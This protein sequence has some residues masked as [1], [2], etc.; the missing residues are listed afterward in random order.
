MRWAFNIH[1]DFVSLIDHPTALPMLEEWVDRKLRLDHACGR[2][3]PGAAH[4]LG[5]RALDRT[6]PLHFEV[7]DVLRDLSGKHN[8]VSSLAPHT[9][10]EVAWACRLMRCDLLHKLTKSVGTTCG[11][12]STGAS[13]SRRSRT[14]SR[15]T[16]VSCSHE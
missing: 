7:H 10:Y 9:R 12:R 5:Q 1:R 3:P 2:G 15:P 6:P 8:A 11:Q 13:R 4:R 16:R 14:E